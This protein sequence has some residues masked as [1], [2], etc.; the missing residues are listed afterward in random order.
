MTDPHVHFRDWNQSAKE[1]VL[2]G[3]ETG[4]KAGFNVFFDMPNTNP[5]VTSNENAI[6]RIHL[7]EHAE[8]EFRERGVEVHYHLYLGITPDPNQ[9]EE[10]VRTYDELFP[11]VCALKM[12][13]SQST[14]DMGIIGKEVQQGIYSRLA[15]LD[16]RGVLAVHCEKEELFARTASRHSDVRPSISEEQSVRDQID[17]AGKAGFKGTLHIAHISTAGALEAVKAAKARGMRITCGA[18]PH[19]ILLNIDAESDIVKM[20]P[21]LRPE[22]DRLAIWN[23]L[24]DGSIDWIESDHAPHTLQDKQNGASGIPG[25]EGMLLTIKALRE[26]GMDEARL[27]ALLCTNALEAFGIN[28]L[29][30]T[31]PRITKRMITEAHKAYPISAWS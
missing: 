18:T 25:F 8:R 23:G 5:P 16:Y 6:Q 3:M 7:G 11:R 24:F 28:D 1:T 10:M 26:A 29:S 20:N 15:E 2:H 12:F 13:A 17:C 22:S 27:N 19:H 30:S 14:G 9:I 4:A 21:P 31:V